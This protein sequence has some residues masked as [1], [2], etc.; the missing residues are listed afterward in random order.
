MNNSYYNNNYYSEDYKLRIQ[1]Y[2]LSSA[3]IQAKK[4]IEYYDNIS[5]FKIL[6]VLR[7]CPP[8]IPGTYNRFTEEE[9]T[10]AVND[11]NSD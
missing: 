9:W 4:Q 1:L 8:L 3:Y 5:E 7:T 11:A 2:L 10:K 6:H